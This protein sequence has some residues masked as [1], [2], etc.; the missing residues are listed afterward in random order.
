MKKIA[1]WLTWAVF[2]AHTVTL[3]IS[4]GIPIAGGGEPWASWRLTACIVVPLV[5]ATA[6]RW[7]GLRR[8]GATVAGFVLFVVGLVLTDLSGLMS[9][10]LRPSH[11]AALYCL[12]LAGSFQFVPFLIFRAK[13]KVGPQ[14]LARTGAGR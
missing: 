3:P 12:C 1:W 14:V 7:L 2:F 10:F 8:V 13:P 11:R 9:L 4:L 6:I 5:V